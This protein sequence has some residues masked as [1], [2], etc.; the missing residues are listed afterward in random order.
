MVIRAITVV[1]VFLIVFAVGFGT[2][3]VYQPSAVRL[4][5]IPLVELKDGQV[6][7]NVATARKIDS[8]Q[9]YFLRPTRSETGSPDWKTR[10]LVVEGNKIHG[11]APP[12]DAT[13]CYMLFTID[14]VIHSSNVVEIDRS[15][16]LEI[17]ADK[18][19]GPPRAKELAVSDRR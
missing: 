18:K 4:V 2:S 16:T 13:Q 7:A 12:S 6:S 1:I 11:D 14:G 8:A 17:L 10:T 19:A 15:P 5:N 9:L 3:N